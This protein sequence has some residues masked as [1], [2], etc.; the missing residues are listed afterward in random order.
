MP[1]QSIVDH[2]YPTEATLAISSTIDATVLPSWLPSEEDIDNAIQGVRSYKFGCLCL[3]PNTVL[4]YEPA[5][6]KASEDFDF[7][8]CAVIDFPNGKLAITQRVVELGR[9]IDAHVS[10]VDIV[11]PVYS[12][13]GGKEAAVKRDLTIL[14]DIAA[15]PG[16]NRPPVLVKVI[17]ETGYWD[18][19]KL[20][21]LVELLNDIPGIAYYKTSTGRE[22]IVPMH[23]KVEHIKTICAHTDRPVK[24]SGG[25]RYLGD[26]LAMKNAGA[27]RFGVG[28]EAAI[29][30][31]EEV[32]GNDLGD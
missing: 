22:P 8:L 6:K 21:E 10:E 11:L 18:R 15:D 14:A 26:Y 24:A 3:D 4:A 12:F 9:V 29:E 30:I 1:K 19:E 17:L 25:I 2:M 23:D 28:L 7:G 16:H 20:I 32:A 5:L 31:I 13:F 27:T